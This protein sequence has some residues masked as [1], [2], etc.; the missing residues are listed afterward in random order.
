MFTKN[1]LKRGAVRP[2]LH[3]VRRSKVTRMDAPE[4]TPAQRL[5]ERERVAKQAIFTCLTLI[6]EQVARDFCHLKTT[7]NVDIVFRQ[8]TVTAILPLTRF[9]YDH[10]S[11]LQAA[12]PP[13]QHAGS[14][15]SPTML[16]ALRD[17]RDASLRARP[18]K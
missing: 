4:R 3:P 18:S 2:G 12:L 8:S 15:D 6:T 13:A 10:A 7:G 17:H 14:G 5:N 11:R 1:F 9:P 16:P